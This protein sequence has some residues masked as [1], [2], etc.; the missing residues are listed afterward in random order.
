[1]SRRIPTSDR[2]KSMG[3]ADAIFSVLM[4][5]SLPCLFRIH[6]LL[7]SGFFCTIFAIRSVESLLCFFP[8]NSTLLCQY[9]FPFHRSPHS[10]HQHERLNSDQVPLLTYTVS[11]LPEASTPQRKPNM[12]HITSNR[13]PS[14]TTIKYRS[15]ESSISS[16]LVQLAV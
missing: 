12:Y 13:T 7:L 9:S 14:Y 4:S 8:F 1:M 11:I 6:I 10:C 2:G 16:S 5:N 15:Q 3:T